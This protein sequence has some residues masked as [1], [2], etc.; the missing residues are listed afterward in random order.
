MDVFY[1]ALFLDDDPEGNGVIGKR[2]LRPTFQYRPW[3]RRPQVTWEGSAVSRAAYSLFT[4]SC[5]SF[6]KW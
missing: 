5:V 3:C 1:L 6:W 2:S 4:L